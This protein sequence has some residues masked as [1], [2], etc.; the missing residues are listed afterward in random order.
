MGKNLPA[1][2]NKKKQIKEY[3][4]QGTGK[5]PAKGGYYQTPGGDFEPD[6]WRAQTEANKEGICTEIIL[7]EQDV[8]HVKVIARAHH[9]DGWYVDGIVNH[10]FNTVMGKK[11]MEMYKK[12]LDGKA[13]TFGVPNRKK[14]IE[15]FKEKE[16]PFFMS[17]D[18]ELIPNLEAMGT[19]KLLDDMLRFRDISIRDATT[20]AM[21]ISQLKA[22][23]EEWRDEEEI[24]AEEQ[25]VKDVNKGKEVIKVDQETVDKAPKAKQSK[26]K[27]PVQP[28]QQNSQTTKE[29]REKAIAEVMAKRKTNEKQEEKSEEEKEEEKEEDVKQERKEESKSV[30]KTESTKQNK[31]VTKQKEPKDKIPSGIDPKKV[32]DGETT[33]KKKGKT[34]KKDENRTGEGQSRWKGLNGKQIVDLIRKTKKVDNK[35]LEPGQVK[36]EMLNLQKGKLITKAQFLDAK[37]Y[38]NDITE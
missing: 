17:D 12:V 26:K 14:R 13:I 18:G 19:A 24:K 28:K 34:G 36:I 27:N 6:A 15:V 8:K 5:I 35:D 16:P 25:E 21:R 32:Q 10:E 11:V 30:N 33:P 2:E 1:V 4:E 7:S 9:P 38:F 23:N 20:K 31:K 22:L 29:E 3:V 37:N